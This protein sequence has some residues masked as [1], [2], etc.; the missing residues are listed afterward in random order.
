MC[1][2]TGLTVALL[3]VPI[4][5]KEKPE[6]VKDR[7][8][9]PATGTGLCVHNAFQ[10]NMVIQRDKPIRVWG[11]AKP[12]DVVT[13][14]FAGKQGSATTNKEGTWSVTLP[15]MPANPAPQQM[16][17]KGKAEA[18]TLDNILLGDIWVLGGQSNM[19][20]PL[21]RVEEGTVEIA[22]ANFPNIRLLTVPPMI[23]HKEKKNFQRRQN[24]QQP[25]GV[26]EVCSPKTVTEFSAIGYA[27]GRRIHIALQIPIG[28]IDASQFGTTVEAWTPLSILRSMDSD[29]VRA[30]L[31]NW[32]KRAAVPWDAQKD[33]DNRIKQF[34]QKMAEQAKQGKPLNHKPPADLRP[35]AIDN[36]N[37][38]GNC[39]AS[40]IA[41]LAGFA[42]K[43]AIWHQGFNN[44]RFDAST[45]YY[46]VFPKMIESWRAAFND[47]KM[48]FGI[49]S[50]CTD[51]TPQTLGNYDEC[52]MD[53]G[54][55]VREAQYK[56]F[57]DYYKAGDKNIGFASSFDLRRAWYHPQQKLP[58]GERIARWALATQ[59]G[60]EKFAFW[61][62]PMIT[63]LEIKDGAIVLHFDSEVGSVDSQAIEGFAIAGED[64]KYQPAHAESLV[65]GKDPKGKPQHNRRILVLDSP[66]VPKPIHFRY[67]WGRN[68]MG[69]LRIA[70]TNEKDI[71][72]PAQRS[73]N[74]QVW[75][76]PHLDPLA[77][78]GES[79]GS[80]DKIREVLKFVDLER[81]VMDAERTL[82]TEKSRYEELKKTF[83]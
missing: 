24:D 53:F 34:N 73:D 77:D 12:G 20:H 78:K 50:L 43:G 37:F 38:P 25:D 11:W 83:K 81:R 59:Y 22:S 16:V 64:K 62:P 26:W 75:E 57:L 10:S 39:Y 13:V 14:S 72:F 2:L 49:I 55:Y 19:Q 79:R 71:S 58:A 30:Q 70:N 3:T 27:F 1:L 80:Q 65:T 67:A 9:A 6:P 7:I 36:Q 56:V 21:S 40:M 41:P 35:A 33:L 5:A 51:G 52:M 61:K 74:W 69:N 47:S 28:L 44:S 66:Y 17:I 82:K 48:P 4:L 42:V 63:Q 18:V 23:G 45:F 46:Q 76:V 29:A 54:I 31:A 32:D 68:P 15:S 60:L 8:D